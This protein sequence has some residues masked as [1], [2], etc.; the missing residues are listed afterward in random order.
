MQ[1]SQKKLW[2][3][4]AEQMQS[5]KGLFGRVKKSAA[6]QTLKTHLDSKDGQSQTDSIKKI[7]EDFEDQK[8]Q[9]ETEA[10][11]QAEAEAEEKGKSD[12]KYTIFSN[13]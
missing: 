1:K 11:R 7:F 8:R 13:S 6:C 9:A 10:K 4:L 3:T 5:D 12:P 2:A